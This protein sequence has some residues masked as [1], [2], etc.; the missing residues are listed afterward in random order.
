MLLYYYSERK[1]KKI[2]STK[3]LRDFSSLQTLYLLKLIIKF[4]ESENETKKH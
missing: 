1:D 4:N 3:P 2:I